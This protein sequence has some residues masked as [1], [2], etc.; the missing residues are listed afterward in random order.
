MLGRTSSDEDTE[1]SGLGRTSRDGDDTVNT[2][3][4]W[5]GSTASIFQSISHASVSSSTNTSTCMDVAGSHTCPDSLWGFGSGAMVGAV[6]I[7]GSGSFILTGGS[8]R[9]AVGSGVI[10]MFWGDGWLGSRFDDADDGM[11]WG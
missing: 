7:S 4:G 10:S 1:D 6:L 3:R 8:S 9:S 11:D 2:G 5:V